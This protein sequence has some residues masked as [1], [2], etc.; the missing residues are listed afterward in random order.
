MLRIKETN[1]VY[2][3]GLQGESRNTS[4]NVI[5]DATK[6]CHGL[7]PKR[8]LVEMLQLIDGK[9]KTQQIIAVGDKSHVF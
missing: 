7:F 4:H 2:W 5:K 6:A 9:I 3:R 1:P 8:L